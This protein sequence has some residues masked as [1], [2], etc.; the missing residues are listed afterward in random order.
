MS[1]NCSSERVCTSEKKVIFL[2][3]FLNSRISDTFL[4]TV[5]GFAKCIHGIG[6]CGGAWVS[7]EPFLFTGLGM[8]PYLSHKKYTNDFSPMIEFKKGDKDSY[9]EYT[10]SIAAFLKCKCSYEN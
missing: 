9:S 5:D 2:Y 6:L 8:R 7:V 10:T 1:A 4:L 3:C